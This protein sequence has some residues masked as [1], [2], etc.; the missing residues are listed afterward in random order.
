MESGHEHAG[1]VERLAL[2]LAGAGLAPG[3][4]FDCPYLPGREAR[5]VVIA[6]PPLRPGGYHALMDLNFRR[7][8]PVYYR[9][10]CERCRECRMLRVR[11]AEHRS[12]RAQRRCAA[13][14]ADLQ[15]EVGPP[16]AS[17]EKLALYERYLDARHDRRMEDSREEFHDYLYTAPAT[18]IEICYRAAGRLVAVGLADAEPLAL[19]AVYCYYD[20]DLAA[21]SPGVFNVLR[22]IDECRRRGAPYLY[23]GY[24]VAD[25][26]KMAY[27]AG[28]H[29]H[30]LWLADGRWQSQPQGRTPSG[31]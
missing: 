28:F 25:S 19:S 20:P 4:A 18:S 22:L 6:T 31:K 27:K 17:D 16:R 30:D 29:P 5:H 7:M 10:Q 23:L 13:R 24:Y 12:T 3:P 26:R 2:A 9:P 1:R 11:V 14:N 21:R 8:G 15:I